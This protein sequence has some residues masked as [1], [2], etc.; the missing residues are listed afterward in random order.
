[1]RFVVVERI[2]I[3]DRS[4]RRIVGRDRQ[5]VAQWRA[6]ADGCKNTVGDHI[7][8]TDSEGLDAIGCRDRERTALSGGFLTGIGTRRFTAAARSKQVV[9]IDAD[10]TTLGFRRQIG[11]RDTVIRSGDRDFQRGS[12]GITVFIG[13]RIAVG[14]RQRVARCK[15]LH[16]RI[17]VIQRVHIAAIGIESNRSIRSRR[18]TIQRHHILRR[19]SIT[20]RVIG[21]H[22]AAHR[23]RTFCNRFGIGYR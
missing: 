16:Q 12:A 10:I 3:S 15:L 14:F 17:G 5:G 21:D 13:Q 1:M 2:G 19:C 23:Y 8:T 4:R 11:D 6:A 18:K 22:R 9:L 7:E 20:Q